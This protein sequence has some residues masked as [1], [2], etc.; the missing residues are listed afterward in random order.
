MFIL[1]KI[2]GEK[3]KEIIRLVENMV[4][5]LE[6]CEEIFIDVCKLYFVDLKLLYW[7]YF[8]EM[9]E[10]LIRLLEFKIFSV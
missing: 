1:L 5:D 2:I 3:L 9:E 7:N 8:F 4:M 6:L 10:F